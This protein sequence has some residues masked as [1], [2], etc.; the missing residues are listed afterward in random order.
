MSEQFT[1]LLPRFLK[2]VKVET[3]SHADRQTIPSSPKETAFLKQLQEELQSLGLTDV[4]LNPA[5]SYLVATIAATLMKRYRSS[6]S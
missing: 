4:H 5:N 6:A 1:T 2:Y 3:R